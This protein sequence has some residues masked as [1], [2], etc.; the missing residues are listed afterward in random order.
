MEEHLD[1]V[2]NKA[3]KLLWDEQKALHKMSEVKQTVVDRISDAALNVEK[4][5][6]VEGQSSGCNPWCQRKKSGPVVKGR[7]RKKSDWQHCNFTLVVFN[8]K[9]LT[10]TRLSQLVQTCYCS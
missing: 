6:S 4:H 7:C 8:Q 5:E 1:G 10:K 2:T 9:T 3:A